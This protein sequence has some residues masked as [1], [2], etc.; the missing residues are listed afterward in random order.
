[1]GYR[2]CC[3]VASEARVFGWDKTGLYDCMTRESVYD[4]VCIFLM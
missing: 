4:S 2:H 1:M 3:L